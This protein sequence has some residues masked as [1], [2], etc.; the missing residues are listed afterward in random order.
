MTAVTR[1]F[2]EHLW[3]I[4]R[5]VWGEKDKSIFLFVILRELSVIYILFPPYHRK[6]TDKLQ[7][8]KEVDTGVVNT[9]NIC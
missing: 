6:L 9:T 3:V 1:T 7:I 2:F 4:Y 8:L 5:I